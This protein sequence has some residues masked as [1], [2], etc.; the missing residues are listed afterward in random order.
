[1]RS[2]WPPLPDGVASEIKSNY[3]ATIAAH[4]HNRW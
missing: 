1:M 2:A 3:D 4:V